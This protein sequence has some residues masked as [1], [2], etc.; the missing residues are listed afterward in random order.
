MTNYLFVYHGGKHPETPE[1][2][3][4]VMKTWKTWLGALGSSAVDAG[5]PVGQSTTVNGDGSVENHGGSNPVAGYGIFAAES[6]DEAIEIAKGCPI[7]TAGGNVELADIF[8]V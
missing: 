8:N 3:E 6:L 1:E 2:T 4:T 5:N 7:L